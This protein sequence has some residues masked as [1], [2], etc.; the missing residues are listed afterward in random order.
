MTLAINITDGRGIS[1]KVHCESKVMLYLPFITQY[2][3]FNQ[4]YITNKTALVLKVGM[5]CRLRSI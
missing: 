1:N 2:K 5:P 3:M 4:L